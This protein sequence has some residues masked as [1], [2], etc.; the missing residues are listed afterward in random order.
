MGSLA[1]HLLEKITSLKKKPTLFFRKLYY[2]YYEDQTET[3]KEHSHCKRTLLLYKISFAY[4]PQEKMQ[5]G[6][7]HINSFQKG[8]IHIFL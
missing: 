6:I 3:Q 4:L 8:R 1:F 5:V 2:H 7:L